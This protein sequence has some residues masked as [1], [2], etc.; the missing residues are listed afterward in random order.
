MKVLQNRFLMIS[1]AIM[2]FMAATRFNHFGS[3]VVL[4]DAS[5]AL[6]F[7]AGMYLGRMRAA[8]L[9]FIALTLE[10]ILIDYYAIATR[11][12]SDWC[13]TNAY[14]F[15]I[16]TY[17]ALWYGGR[18][19]ARHH[20]YTVKSLLGLFTTVAVASLAAFVI[21]NASFYLFSGRY[22][23]MSAADYAV[24]VVQYLGSYVIVAVM[25]VA[26]AVAIE[27][28]AQLILK[29]RSDQNTRPV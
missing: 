26:V 16:F 8:L 3:S 21:S 9:F 22:A 17:A 6:Y 4:P 15:M 18:W 12:V 24:S 11:G 2:L 10:A 1:I 29:G 23:N 20:T 25:Y 27:M 13:V 28:S 5:W 19:F 7:L 14:G